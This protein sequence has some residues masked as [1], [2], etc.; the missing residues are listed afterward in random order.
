MQDI[1]KLK[2]I[3]QKLLTDPFFAISVVNLDNQNCIVKN[4]TGA[5]LTQEYGSPVAFFEIQKNNGVSAISILNRRKNGTNWYDSSA[6]P[7]FVYNFPGNAK[8][9]VATPIQQTVATPTPTVL[10]QPTALNGFTQLSIP[11]YTDLHYKARRYDEQVAIHEKTLS[12][13][14]AAQ[15][16]IED[17]KKKETS[18][19]SEIKKAAAVDEKIIKYINAAGEHFGE[20]I[21]H[22]IKSMTPTRALEEVAKQEIGLGNPN[23][24]EAKNEFIKAVSLED[25]Q[26][27]D[28][29]SDTF[30]YL[31]NPQTT[32]DFR[33]ALTDLLT[34]TDPENGL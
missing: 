27:I 32:D 30:Y 29:L 7:A 22:F 2:E 13:L 31:K 4:K 26:A 17:F 20:G 34:K 28:L 14:E 23:F 8:T 10:A 9:I 3:T 25:D 11:E 21:N 19:D 15:A 16:E 33:V 5:M 12:K 18:G 6:P 24:S 1:E